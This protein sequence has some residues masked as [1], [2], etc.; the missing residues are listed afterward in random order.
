MTHLSSLALQRHLDV[1]SLASA[2]LLLSDHVDRDLFSE[3]SSRKLFSPSAFPVQKTHL[4]TARLEA[5]PPANRYPDPQVS[6]SRVWLPSQS[7]LF[8]I[9]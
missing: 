7:D 5:Y 6:L 1:L 2:T 3:S 4:S 8:L 9:S